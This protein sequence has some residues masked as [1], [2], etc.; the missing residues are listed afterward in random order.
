MKKNIYQLQFLTPL[1]DARILTSLVD[2][3]WLVGFMFNVKWLGRK[4]SCGKNA[5]PN[6]D[7][8]L[9]PKNLE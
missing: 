7:I 5:K 8:F 3:I 4:K 9:Y 6:K 2:A 1:I